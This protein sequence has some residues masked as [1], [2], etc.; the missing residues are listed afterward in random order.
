MVYEKLITINVFM[1][2]LNIP[3]LCMVTVTLLVK[4]I[5]AKF[6]K[7][8]LLSEKKEQKLV[9]FYVFYVLIE[10]QPLCT[11]TFFELDFGLSVAIRF[12]LLAKFFKANLL[13]EKKE[14][15]LVTFLCILCFN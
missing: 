6:F 9:T 8:N 4:N 1:F 10:F 13:S 7:A 2:K 14:Q 15:K 12:F 3:V 11:V 5:E